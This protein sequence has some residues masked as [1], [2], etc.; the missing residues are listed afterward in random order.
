MK[1]N[2]KAMRTIALLL[3]AVLMGVMLTACTGGTTEKE[4]ELKTITVSEVTHS[5][6]YAPQYVAL[7]LGFFE[8]EGLKI[9]MISGE[10]ADKVMTSL[11]SGAV[12]IGFS[13]PEAA[14]YIHNE[15]K[16]DFAKVFAQV[17]KRDGSFLMA[18]EQDDDFTWDKLKG[19][20]L[21][22]GRKGGVPYMALEYVVK[23]KGLVPNVDIHFDNS[24]QFA[25]MTGAFVGG[26]GDYVTVFEPTASSLEKEGKGYIVASVG[27][28]AGEIPY[29]AYYALNSYI[30]KNPNI[31]QGF[32]NALYKAQKWV[33]SHTAKEIAAAIVPQ[34][35]DAD[36]EVMEKAIQRYKDIDAYATAPMMTED[37]FDRLQLVMEEAGELNQKAPYAEIVDN[38]F[39]EKAVKE[40]K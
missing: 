6:F 12:D 33:E 9:E 17:T 34:F 25:A 7:E 24:I 22:P 10:G 3:A 5:V 38:T 37:S 29:T 32:T 36:M 14:I 21:L 18:R 8:E 31:I 1:H 20:H 13:G 40:V 19:K 2:K 15:G 4:K 28:E 16:E 39:G 23:Q 35:P 11:I 30:E 27:E 26:T